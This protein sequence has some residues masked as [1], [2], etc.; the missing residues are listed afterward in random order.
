MAQP[1]PTTT[2]VGVIGAGAMGAGIAEVAARAGHKVWIA[3]AR[4]DAVERALAA[5]ARDLRGLAAKG[6]IAAA[7][8][9]AA[10]ARIES[11]P[12]PRFADCGLVIEAIVEDLETKRSLL[13]TLEGIVGSDAI[14]A[15]NTSS[16]S[17][18]AIAAGLSHP[19]RVVGMHFF[20]PATRMKL[21]EVVSGVETAA[22]IADAVFATAE[23]WGKKPA[24]AKSTPG[25][26]VNRI[27]RPFYGEAWRAYTEG[28]A[29]P[30]TIDAI[31]RDCGGF[32]MG[33]FELMDLIGHDVNLAV[34]AAV[35]D[36]TFGERRYAP[37]LAQ[38]ELVRA[39][40][41][42]RKSGRGIYDYRD[43]AVKPL[44]RVEPGAEPV[45]RVV[46]VGSLGIA[47]PIITRLEA[48]GV[49]V[50]RV[51]GPRAAQDV[52]AGWLEVG[53]ARLM[54]TDGR[55]ATR[56][57]MEEKHEHL[58]LFDLALDYATT[59]RLGL[60]RA[61]QCGMAA[62]RTVCAT[63]GQAGYACSPLDDVAGLVVMRLIAMLVNEAADAVAYGTCSAE[64]IDVAM[65]YGVNYP[66]GP[67]EWSE[68]VGLR[69]FARALA[70]LREH[71][72]EE[73]Y[74]TSALIT[75]KGYTGAGFHE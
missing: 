1:L 40:H 41:L 74:R 58:V 6:R 64:A 65:R 36:A 63:L 54:M 11:A 51:Q 16:L 48:A 73:R 9:E 72:G 47:T 37:S 35:F 27:A 30:A 61:D 14:L 66:R 71:Y 33:P 57:A 8:A 70:N 32:P 52:S 17:V 12:L 4:A 19:E 43:G 67:M 15:T 7:D 60:A 31:V 62:F 10:V 42:G 23:A 13:R 26:I 18:T 69:V 5:I 21:V 34:S 56:R 28:A 44:P 68:Q 39:G 22:G 20:N 46:A 2:V 38:Q 59:P 24:Y 75:R 3:D 50:V 55:P 45:R 49:D 25:F 53:P 29:D